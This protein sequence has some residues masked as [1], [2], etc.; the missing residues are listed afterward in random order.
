MCLVSQKKKI[1][2]LIMNETAEPVRFVSAVSHS[3]CVWASIMDRIGICN[4]NKDL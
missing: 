4:A 1:E 3:V 2:K